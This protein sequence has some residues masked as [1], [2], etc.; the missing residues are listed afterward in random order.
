MNTELVALVFAWLSNNGFVAV[1]VL[2]A[3]TPIL[4]MAVAGY[5]V[6]VLGKSLGKG[7]QK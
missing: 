5:V 4:A 6:H 2:F 1:V 7:K 3:L